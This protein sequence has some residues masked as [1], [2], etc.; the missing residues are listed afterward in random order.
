M[1][2]FIRDF[3]YAFRLTRKSPRFAL[4]VIAPLALGIGLNG[5]I[6]LLVDTLLLRPLPVNN[7]NEL[8]RIV[9][10]IQNL[11]PRGYYTYDTLRAL[12]KRCTSFSDIAAYAD[13]NAAVRD[14]SGASRIRAQI[15]TGNFFTALGV[16]A[17]Y[18]RALTSA[19][20]LQV[21][22]RP[23]VVLS[24]PYW[25]QQLHAD[26]NVIGQNL[27]LED[28]QFVI[29]G[30]MPRAFNGIEAETTP[31]IRVPL[32]AAGMLARGNTNVD[33][34]L[35]F[36]YSLFARLR[37]GVS[38]SAAQAEATSI[39]D[40]LKEVQD[41]R[42]V[43]DEHL[44]VQSIAK[45]VSLIRPK[46][47]NALI[48]LMCGV[49][50][51]LLMICANV[52]G[53]LLARTAAR[54]EEVAVRL[55]IG[56]TTGR[57]LSQFL[58]ESLV[59]AAI[60]C[61]AGVWLAILATPLILRG[62]PVVRDLGATALTLSLDIRP[63]ARFYSFAIALCVICALFAGLPAA[64]Q[65]IRGDLNTELRSTR[66]TARQPLRWA[67]VALQIGLCTFLLAGAGLLV[68]TFERLRA[69]DPGFDRDHIVT[70]SIDPDM[71]HYKPEEVPALQQ[72]LAD[73]V[74][75]LPGVQSDGIAVIGLMRGT[76]MKTTVAPEGQIAP[77]SDF[78]NTS[79]NS[80]TPDYFETM[81]IPV[82]EG[83]NFRPN[84]PEAKPAPV[85]VNRAFVRRFFPTVDP[86]GRKLGTG[87]EKVAAG[88]YEIVG[89]VG[90]AKYRNLRETIPPT[91]YRPFHPD[92]KFTS[93]FILN[94]RTRNQPDGIIQPVRRALDSIDPRLP[95]YE[96]HTL[97]EEVNATLWAER[98][99]AWLSGVFSVVAAILATLGIY[100][101]LAYA[102]AQ[103]RREIGIRVALGAGAA[104][105]LG[106]F[107]SRPLRYAVSGMALGLLGFWAATP[108]FRSLLYEVSS[109]DPWNMICAAAA[110]LLIALISTLVAAGGAL[111]LDPAAVLR[112]E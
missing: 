70:F 91:M 6:F 87:T 51:L 54:R 41:G 81:R 89:V 50:L 68:S 13:W 76:G 9:Q 49:G 56:G 102:I 7:P 36:E 2:H 53:L 20:E 83:R 55:A 75:L 46:F 33:S 35:K 63:D 47:A 65:A 37:P 97:A 92:L 78:L 101:T 94:V 107:S 100:A 17:Q 27:K 26:P 28:Q 60:G 59:L 16:Q 66:G 98:F 67:L 79:L 109:S 32:I 34:Y 3:S 22:A 5:A 52:G 18:G 40:A 12:R 74:R 24:Y 1:T 71:A 11:G 58:T 48:L 30:V 21:T 38:V 110:V 112:E 10:V 85:I 42:S 73:A 106:R 45:G 103:S 57:L 44:E 31:D 15:V 19:D 93:A 77:R 105:I 95:F 14:A 82:L 64:F 96:V 86:I 90:D 39:V 69:L 84:E 111:R 8:V 99:L 29:V 108:A 88:E 62:M 23:P 4:S 104:D 43:R 80:V 25:H 72:R 61:A